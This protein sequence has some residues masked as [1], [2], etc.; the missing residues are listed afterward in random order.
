M[1]IGISYLKV[2]GV[3]RVPQ[4]SPAQQL[5]QPHRAAPRRQQGNL[6]PYGGFHHLRK[7]VS[8]V[9]FANIL[10]LIREM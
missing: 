9:F 1:L 4:R 2:K 8:N 3:L 10:L 7:I 5:W 6:R